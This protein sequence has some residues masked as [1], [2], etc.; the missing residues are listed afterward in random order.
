MIDGF[1]S[2]TGFSFGMR[3][4]LKVCDGFVFL[5]SV[6]DELYVVF[7]CPLIFLDLLNFRL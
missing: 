4:F 1:I 7:F 5:S 3:S 2:E 6:T